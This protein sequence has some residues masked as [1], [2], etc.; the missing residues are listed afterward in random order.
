MAARHIKRKK[1][2][3]PR[4]NTLKKESKKKLNKENKKRA[5]K[6]AT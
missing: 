3:I 5:S 1:P 4:Q 2:L 6:A